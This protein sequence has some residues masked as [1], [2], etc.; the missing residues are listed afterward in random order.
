MHIDHLDPT[1]TS[2][3]LEPEHTTDRYVRLRST[4]GRAFI[5]LTKEDVVNLL[6]AMDDEAERER[7]RPTFNGHASPGYWANSLAGLRVPSGDSEVKALAEAA[8]D[9]NPADSW[10]TGE[11][12]D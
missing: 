11:H 3:G 6:V 7:P 4:D 5:V 1:I 12:E 2:S 8:R 9:W 10:R